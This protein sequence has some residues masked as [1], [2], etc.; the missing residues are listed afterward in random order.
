MNICASNLIS[1]NFSMNQ[2]NHVPLCVCILTTLSS[3][4][5]SGNPSIKAIPYEM[6]MLTKLEQLNIAGLKK[7]REPLK[8]FNISSSQDC[9]SYLK[10]KIG[11]SSSG[12]K[13]IQLMIV[14]N[15][16][17]GKRTFASRL[18]GRDL[19]QNLVTRVCVSEWDCH[20]SFKNS[21]HFRVW[22]FKSLEDNKAIY[23]TTVSCLSVPSIC[24]YLT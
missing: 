8:P 16:G 2:F 24:C 15:S 17:V 4:D 22:V 5:I 19:H 1:L 18:H 6:G 21:V 14:G 3:L 13:S 11:H 12:L 23:I 7:L 20:Q 10:G 9:I